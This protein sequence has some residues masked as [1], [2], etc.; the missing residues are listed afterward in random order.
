MKVVIEVRRPQGVTLG[1]SRMPWT[2]NALLFLVILNLVAVVVI[3]IGWYG[4]STRGTVSSQTPWA[5]AA[6]VGA[7]LAGIADCM[8]L[9]QGRRAI[10]EQ[11][12]TLLTLE[13]W[14]ARTA[15]VLPPAASDQLVRAAGMSRVHRPH[16][17]LVAGKKTSVVRR[18]G[19]AQRCGICGS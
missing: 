6:I 4:A 15:N 7:I 12:R 1:S 18:P 9:L 8:W 19:S 11:R 14:Q 3:V 10:G 5:D 2:I 17:P 16:C 13:S